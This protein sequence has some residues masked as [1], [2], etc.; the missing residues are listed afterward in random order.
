MK[1]I[2]KYRKIDEIWTKVGKLS[3]SSSGQLL[4]K[5]TKNRN[6]VI[7]L[8]AQKEFKSKVG[9]TKEYN[10]SW[11]GLHLSLVFFMLPPS[12]DKEGIRRLPNQP[13]YHIPATKVCNCFDRNNNVKHKFIQHQHT[14]TFNIQRIKKNLCQI[15]LNAVCGPL[16]VPYLPFIIF[17]FWKIAVGK[18]FLF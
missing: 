12:D 8:N 17:F 16:F 3:L 18:G 11:E 5:S 15:W 9:H 7:Y 2:Q 14:E 4:V 6:I 13:L 1:I 10:L